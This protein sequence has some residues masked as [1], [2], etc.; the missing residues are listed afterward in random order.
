MLFKWGYIIQQLLALLTVHAFKVSLIILT[1]WFQAREAKIINR[2][3]GF[4]ALPLCNIG[5]FYESTSQLIVPRYFLIEYSWYQV[6]TSSE[7]G[8]RCLENTTSLYH[9]FEILDQVKICIKLTSLKMRLFVSFWPSE[10][11]TSDIKFG[12]KVMMTMMC[13]NAG[14]I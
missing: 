9:T 2:L 14:Q 1:L 3:A 6:N 5:L 4:E 12:F 10:A 7:K 13:C 8:S 11:Q